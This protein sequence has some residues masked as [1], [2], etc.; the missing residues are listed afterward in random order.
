MSHTKLNQTTAMSSA[1]SLQEVKES[2]A[3]VCKTLDGKEWVLGNSSL[4]GKGYTD[5]GQ[6]LS[7][8]RHVRYLDGSSN[9]LGNM[10]SCF[11]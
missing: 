9:E 1:P 11:R 2:L 6:A 7:T 10:V 4:S 5:L 8:F 3:D